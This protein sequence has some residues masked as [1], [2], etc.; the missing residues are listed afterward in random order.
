MNDEPRMRE[1]A[2]L[3]VDGIFTDRPAALRAALRS[4]LAP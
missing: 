4:T 3:E 1:L 2:A